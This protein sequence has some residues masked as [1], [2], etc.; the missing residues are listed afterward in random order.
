M[1]CQVQLLACLILSEPAA[2]AGRR[3]SPRRECRH[4]AGTVGLPAPIG[5][6]PVTSTVRVGP[7]QGLVGS[8]EHCGGAP[9]WGSR[10]RD[11][12]YLARANR[13]ERIVPIW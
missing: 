2:G 5:T 13:A 1:N 3:R 4:C 8:G 12:T 10:W 7:A 11:V 9:Y 6:S